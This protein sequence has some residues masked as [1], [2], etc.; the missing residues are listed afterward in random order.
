MSVTF[1]CSSAPSKMVERPC[2]FPGCEPGNRCGYCEDG[3]ER[4][5]VSDAPEINWANGN[6][7]PIL[8]LLGLEADD[9]YG[10]L[11]VEAIPAVRRTIMGLLN[12]ESQRAPALREFEE[13][14][15]DEVREVTHEGNLAT[16][17]VRRTCRCIVAGL[18]DAG[19][20]RRL[21]QCD[22]LLAYAQEHSFEVSWG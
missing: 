9:L 1:G 2:D 8:S 13:F 15:G 3:I 21:R 12:V 17:S 11:S 20:E 7:R 10:S 18:D 5:R 14:G 6:A 4:E 22:A 16:I 19:V